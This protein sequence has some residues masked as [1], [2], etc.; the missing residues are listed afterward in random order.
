MLRIAATHKVGVLLGMNDA[1]ERHIGGN[2]LPH[3]VGERL[4]EERCI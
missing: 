3:V 2:L 4:I 1:M